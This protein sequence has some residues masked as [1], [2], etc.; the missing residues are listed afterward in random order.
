MRTDKVSRAATSLGQCR[1]AVRTPQR[2]S[3]AVLVAVRE[4]G[5]GCGVD[6]GKHVPELLEFV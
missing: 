2:R 6:G 1:R 5:V 4:G 3:A